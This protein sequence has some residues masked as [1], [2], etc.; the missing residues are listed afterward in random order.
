M[1]KI[2]AGIG[3]LMVLW[4]SVGLSACVD[5]RAVNPGQSVSSNDPLPQPTATLNEADYEMGEINAVDEISLNVMESFPLQVSVTVR[6][7][8]PDGCT[9]IADSEVEREGNAFTVKIT[10]RRSK[11][12]VC[13]QALVPFEKN[14]SLDVYGLPAGTYTVKVYNQSA[15]FNFDMDNSLPE[16]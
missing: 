13:T 6:G 8:L 12:A 16:E 15:E 3:F 10:T 1:K 9:E 5:G 11:D 4:L 14:I 7:N 2:R